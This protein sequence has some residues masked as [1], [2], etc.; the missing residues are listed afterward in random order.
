[1]AQN[2]IKDVATLK[3][4]QVAAEFTGKLNDAQRRFGPGAF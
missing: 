3:N 4:T 2:N 1:M